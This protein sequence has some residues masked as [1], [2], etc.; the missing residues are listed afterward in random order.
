[1]GAW[2]MVPMPM[3]VDAESTV[4]VWGTTVDDRLWVGTERGTL[5]YTDFYA[6]GF[7]VIPGSTT[8]LTVSA[9]AIWGSAGAQPHIYIVSYD[10]TVTHYD[11]AADS[12][13]HYLVTSGP[14]QALYTVGGV[15]NDVYAVGANNIIMHTT[16]GSDEWEMQAPPVAGT[17][18]L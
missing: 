10:G 18:M 1:D 2:Q 13:K 11:S 16:V 6:N 7:T 14:D 9:E 15:G 12:W 5:F 3:G 8:G 17:T 4:S